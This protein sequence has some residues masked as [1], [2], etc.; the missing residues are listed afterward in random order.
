MAKGID[1]AVE[2]VNASGGIL[3]KKVVLIK[4]DGKS[5]PAES[6]NAAKK[7][8]EQDGVVAIIGEAAS[9]NSLAVAPIAKQARQLGLTQAF[10]GTDGWDSPKLTEIAGNA[11]K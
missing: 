8:I 11:T 10:L 1:L 7:L 6:A 3:D 9:S 5:E 4:E 2:E